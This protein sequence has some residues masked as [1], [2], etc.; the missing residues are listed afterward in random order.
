M[1]FLWPVMFCAAAG[2][3]GLSDADLDAVFAL[4][5]EDCI[6]EE[7]HLGIVSGQLTTGINHR[8]VGSVAGLWAPPY[9]SSDFLLEMQVAGEK[10]PTREY[11]WRPMEV[12]RSGGTGDVEVFSTTTLVPGTRAGILTLDLESRALAPQDVDLRFVV[13]GTLD[14]TD[15][16]EFSRAQSATPAPAKVEENHLVKEQGPQAVVLRADLE[17]L[18]WDVDTSAWKTT[19]ALAP[20]EKRT[21]HVVFAIGE[22][23]ASVAQCDALAA[24][25]QVWPS[26]MRSPRTPSR[27]SRMR[28]WSIGGGSVSFS[29]SSRS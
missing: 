9:V 10:V 16:W 1:I 26:V 20:H 8:D 22:K 12:R 21:I 28:G 17:G 19:L 13:K 7:E 3:A 2:A 27:Q 18:Q 25:P 4:R 15:V 5:G 11:T 23:S 29:T 14:R 24:D 6:M